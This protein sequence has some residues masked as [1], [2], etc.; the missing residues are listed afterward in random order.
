MWGKKHSSTVIYI[1]IFNLKVICT[2]SIWICNITHFINKYSFVKFKTTTAA[3]IIDYRVEIIRN[4]HNANKIYNH[5]PQNLVHT[6]L[7]DRMN[8]VCNAVDD[9]KSSWDALW[10]PS[11]L[12]ITGRV[13]RV[14]DTE[15]VLL[16]TH[17]IRPPGSIP[18]VGWVVQLWDLSAWESV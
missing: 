4:H 2:S 11:V 13:S 8:N 1:T 14:T 10:C 7:F 3:A 15:L 9:H 18:G 17:L 16:I 6:C 12:G 5:D